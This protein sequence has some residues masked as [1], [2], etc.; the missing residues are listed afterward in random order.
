MTAYVATRH[1]ER[2]TG[3]VDGVDPRMRQRPRARDRHAAGASAQIEHPPHPPRLDPR[4]EAP[5]DQLG[6]R[7]ARD[8]HTRI[9]LDAR[10]GEPGDT[11]EVRSRDALADTARE[12]LP[13]PLLCRATDAPAIERGAPRVPQ[14]ESMQHQ[15]RGLI[16]GIVGAVAEEN[17]CTRE[18]SRATL[19]E[20]AH[21]DGAGLVLHRASRAPGAWRCVK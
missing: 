15:R 11:G 6:K 14:A 1:L 20:C 4:P 21:G 9:D 2:I 7:R 19:D 8:E 3:D 10:A 18:A 12:Q 16:P 13:Y 17:T 5:L